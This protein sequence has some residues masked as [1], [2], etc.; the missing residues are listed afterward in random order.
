MQPDQQKQSQLPNPKQTTGQ[1]GAVFVDAEPPRQAPTNSPPQAVNRGTFMSDLNPGAVIPG[2]PNSPIQNPGGSKANINPNST[3]NSLQIAEIRDGIVIMNDGS[4]RSVVMVK[5]INFD[6]MSPQEREGV[7]FS[8]Q[9]F[10]NSLYYPV[11]IFIRSQKVDIRP[12]LEKLDK[13]RAEHDNMLLAMLMDDYIGYID[14]LAAEANIMDKHFYVVIPF[15]PL[16]ESKKQKPLTSSKNLMDGIFGVFSKTS[17]HVVITEADLEEAKTELRNRVQATLSGLMQCG[18]Q[19]LPLD[20]QELIE[21]YYDAY[22]PDTATRQQLKSFDNLS[23][24]VITKGEGQAP[25]PN[26]DKELH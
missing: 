10:L 3:Q 4:F 21:L 17:T 11:Q 1:Q 24:P 15:F 23:A 8:F 19:G 22:N 14:S 13:I 26:L 7:E 5:S 18:V 6:L 16:T 9:G 20:T 12:Y 2:D 25:Q